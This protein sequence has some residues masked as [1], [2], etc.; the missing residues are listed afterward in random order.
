MPVR[1]EKDPERRQ[2]RRDDR[3]RNTRGGT[4]G[5]GGFGQLLPFILPLLF[6]NKKLLLLA[7]I[8]GGIWFFF[9]GG[10]ESLF[11]GLEGGGAINSADD[12]N[13]QFS[14]G[15]ALSE[16]EYYKADVYEP[17][18]PV[19]AFGAPQLPT[20]ISLLKYAPKRMHQ[21]RQGSCV[22][23]AASYAARTILQSRA[24]GKSPDNVAFS[25][26]FLYNHIALQGCQGAYMNN[27]MEFLHQ[28]G[29]LPFS[30]FEYDER[31]CSRQADRTQ[32]ARAAQYRTKGY[33][34]LS[35]GARDFGVD[36]NGVRQHLAAGAPVVVGMMVGGTFMHQMV[37]KGYWRPTRRDY[38]QYGFSG[39]AMCVIGYD[40]NEQTVEIMNSWGP[41]W[42]R[43]GIAKISYRDF[44]HF[45]KEAYGLYPMGNAAKYDPNKLA[46]KFGLVENA[47][48][49]L[50]PLTEA[51]DRVF[52]TRTPIPK[53]T[54]FKVAITNSI[55]C[56]VYVF[57][58]ETDGSSYVLFPY[59]EKH[60]P[61]C[62]ITGTR[63][64]PRD[65]SMTPD[66]IG[67]RDYIAIVVSKKEL[68]W[69]VLNSRI[70]ASRR[71]TYIAK[72]RDAIGSEEVPNVRFSAPD[73]VEFSCNL[74]G[75]N[76]VATVIEIDK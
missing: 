29:D 34:R 65:H 64:F 41:E 19:R 15:A 50:I 59:T 11:G 17:L 5:G 67:N 57:G 27:A 74:N 23:W 24:T 72:V 48:Q 52:R 2:P 6:K 63:L 71:P 44:L 35:N 21:G 42:G 46:V 33:N 8:A 14:F 3:R 45:T 70:N 7:I 22:G 56:Y 53:G 4:R 30:Q 73:A 51:G 39:H 31:S 13:T 58:Q 68:D 47:S 32:L 18:S 76:I 20:K 1:M 38:Q 28:N 43:N 25:P 60:S 10:S 40:D 37:G 12:Y 9:L 55:E 61:Y 49:T 54:K 16:E 66:N 26:S 69:N 36:L 75:K 62:G